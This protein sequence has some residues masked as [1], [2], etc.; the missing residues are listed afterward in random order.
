MKVYV[1]ELLLI[2]SGLL[3]TT[4]QVYPQ[5]YPHGRF[6]L[7]GGFGW[8]EM[9]A[10]KIKY[11]ENFQVG[12]S[13]G[14]ILNTS[15]E[16]Y[17]HFAGKAKHTNQQVWYG[18]GGLDCLYWGVDRTNWFPYVRLGR[19]FNLSRKYGLNLDFGSLYLMSESDFF[20]RSHFSPS[21]SL[22]LFIRF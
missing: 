14:F 17:Y 6:E 3:L 18:L 22:S 13:Q 20:S 21:G 5:K 10:L 16:I 19:T 7:A 9:G 11:G 1:F 8:P 15:I 2:L 12:L 4:D